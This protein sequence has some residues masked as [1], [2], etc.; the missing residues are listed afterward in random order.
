[1]P[2][3]FIYTS[4]RMEILAERLARIVRTPLPSPLAPEIVVVQSRGM[5]RWISMTL[6]ERN[7]VSAN[8]LFPFPNAFLEDIFRRMLPD[9]PDI[10]P[11][12]RTLMTFRLM[13][14]IPGQL[15]QTQFA[16][17]KSYL[18]DDDHQLKLFQLSHKI[19]DLFDQYLVFRPE[20]IFQWEQGQA[21]KQPPHQWQADLWR[22]LTA[23]SG[24]RHRA[25]LQKMFLDKIHHPDGG[26]IDLPSR[27]SI[28]GISYLPLFHLQAFAALSEVIDV[29]FFLIDPCREYW[30]DIVSDRE[31]KQIRRKH[32]RIA[33]NI[34]W[35]HFEKGN[36]LLASM[37]TLGRDFFEL[38]AGFDCEI[39]EHFLDPG[40]ET[41]LARLQ[42]D[43]LN[44][45]NRQRPASV[46][47]G[48]S[49]AA[50]QS[51]ETSAGPAPI[52]KED[53]SVQ[54]HSCHGPMREVEVLHDNLLA[55]FEEDPDLMPKDIIVMT[56]DIE[57]YAPYVQA[58]FGAQTDEALRI[59]FSIAD[60]SPRR[61]SRLIA[62]FLALL[63]LAGSRFGAVQVTRLLEF[64]GIKERFGLAA[65][66]LKLIE[67]WI[68][69]TQIRWGIDE[70][71]RL[72]AG[73]PGFAENTWRAG[74]DRLLLGY[75]MP[76]ENKTIFHGIVP[77]D[78][79][80]GAEAQILGRFLE[81]T[82]RLFAWAR[83]LA[84]PRKLS[85]WHQLLAD[86]LDQFFKPEEADE[87]EWQ[88]LRLTLNDMRAKEA[89]AEFHN[90][91]TLDVIHAYL[92]SL[93][94]QNSYGAGF[95]SGG[96]TFCAML[97]MRSIPF[98]VICLIGMNDEAF[99]RD[100]Q[101]LNFDLMARYPKT[102]DRS[103]RSDDK[104][105][106]LESLVSARQK[107]Y[108]SYVG[109]NIQ[110]N[111]RIPP[112]VLVSELLDTIAGSFASQGGEDILEQIVTTHRLQAFSP[113]YFR[114]DS[115][116][117]SYCAENM[118]AA[119]GACAK[120]IPPVFF[121]EKLA[122]TPEEAEEWH[123]LDLDTVH[124]FFSNPA[125]FLIR[126]RLG[127]RLPD[128]AHLS[129]E[130]EIFDL[131][132]LDRY[133]VEQNLIN[134][135]RAGV[136]PESF[137]PI[138]KA[139]GQLPHGNIGEYHYA[140]MSL[141]VQTFLRKIEKFTATLS[142]APLEA[143]LAAA[144]FHLSGRLTG[145]SGHG[146]VHIR[147]ARRRVA[148]LFKAWIYHLVYGLTAPSNY[149]QSSFLICKDSAIQFEPVADG[150]P[151][152][153]DLLG[154]LRRG[155][156]QPIHFFPK[157]SYA[158]A[159]HLLKKEASESAALARARKKWLGS[160]SAKFS[161]GE[162]A[163]PFFDLCFRRLDPIDD[164]FQ[165]IA[166]QVFKPMFAHLREIIL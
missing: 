55:M 110:D 136:S 69:K 61:T 47:R 18:A 112:S 141:D 106:F 52:S 117:F 16:S 123:A 111:S 144:G 65:S 121:A 126:R 159:E 58:V 85:E 149:K 57:M 165:K 40:Q 84:K 54:I 116:L 51:F 133:Q 29:N 73:L 80:E 53:T 41:V 30:A 60:Q 94:E 32:P 81:F 77:Y 6:A 162:C 2:G 115:G 35:Y 105:L 45:R 20:L 50:E 33:E 157:S 108:I 34:A 21:E 113:L 63:E 142:A 100:Y 43:I 64:P 10:S 4:N 11:Y 42:S 161:A 24:R 153:E 68:K 129:D 103:R 7:G 74:L 91:V 147:Y 70:N 150:L 145:I 17:L 96:V 38:I 1:M 86:L 135:L 82:D 127:I 44:L 19:A 151:V 163:D 139:A 107:F 36:Q 138:P 152:L 140:E 22:G 39:G 109:Q 146:C 132:A 83:S 79:I 75:A 12:D 28:F 101:P 66:D 37:G 8:C 164:S 98:K 56:P 9:L 3:L 78:D 67:Q 49:S 88:L 148:D 95:L 125:M 46:G 124:L 114:E 154:L 118:L 90:A 92:K 102:G 160:D 158:Y 27:V 14:I 62:G 155:L 25:Y 131:E 13:Q 48:R 76:G 120:K 26:Q 5:E 72:E 122:L 134:S 99:P 97:P 93:L 130:R 156:E 104:Y 71:S 59:P 31:L 87:R 166:V 15:E 119:A 137:K 23:A 128:E 89:Q 143:D